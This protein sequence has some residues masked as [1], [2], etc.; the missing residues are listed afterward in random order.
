M[1]EDHN[2]FLCEIPDCQECEAFQNRL[3]QSSENEAEDVQTF[4]HCETC[5]ARLEQHLVE[6][7]LFEID[8]ISYLDAIMGNQ[9]ELDEETEE[10]WSPYLC[11]NDDCEECNALRELDALISGQEPVNPVQ[12]PWSKDEDESD[13]KHPEVCS[14]DQCQDCMEF[15][16]MIESSEDGESSLQGQQVIDTDELFESLNEVAQKVWSPSI[17]E[18]ENEMYVQYMSWPKLDR[19]KLLDHFN[20]LCT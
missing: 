2:P 3:E 10:D 13:L 11:F 8:H 14:N 17:K 12:R 6:G 7:Y 20:A 16:K 5:Q 1:N 9:D 19:L 18:G 15:K 4:N